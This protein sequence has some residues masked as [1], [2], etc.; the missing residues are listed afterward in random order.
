LQQWLEW[1]IFGGVKSYSCHLPQQ[2]DCPS[3]FVM[4]FPDQFGGKSDLGRVGHHRA[5]Q[6]ALHPIESARTLFW[7]ANMTWPAIAEE[8]RLA[9]N[10]HGDL[11]M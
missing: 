11:R 7:V 8:N 2:V 1:Q 4:I 10:G 3:E 9:G 5:L 6:W